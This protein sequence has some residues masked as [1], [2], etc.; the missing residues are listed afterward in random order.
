MT[1][2]PTLLALADRCEAATGPDRD[3][4]ALIH[5]ACVATWATADEW[6]KV[7]NGP[8]GREAV[9][10]Y[11]ASIDAAM[12]LANKI[13]VI[14]HMSDIGADGLPLVWLADPS[15]TPTREWTGIARTLPLA[16]CAAALRARAAQADIGGGG[17]L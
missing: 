5:Q 15:T 13:A 16:F 1:D 11:T 6:V 2:A 3:L 17:G 12:T 9:F 7:V 14:L 8:F 10:D 4:D